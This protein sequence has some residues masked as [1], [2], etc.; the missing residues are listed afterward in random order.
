MQIV[1]PF[2]LYKW[3]IIIIIIIIKFII[4]LALCAITNI[5]LLVFNL[6]NIA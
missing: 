1:I 4:I 2:I 5:N 3:N 6:W